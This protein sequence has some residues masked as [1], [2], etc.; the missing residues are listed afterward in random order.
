MSSCLTAST[1]MHF[2]LKKSA[3]RSHHAGHLLQQQGAEVGEGEEEEV[4]EDAD[5][6]VVAVPE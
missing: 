4:G 6:E 2:L 3:S 5:G 1:W